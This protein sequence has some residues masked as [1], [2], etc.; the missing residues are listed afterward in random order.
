[1]QLKVICPRGRPGS[2]WG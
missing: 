1:M 2:R